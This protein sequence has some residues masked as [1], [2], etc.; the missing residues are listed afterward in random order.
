[1][2]NE[3]KYHIWINF[4]AFL[5]MS[6]L[7][8]G[9]DLI[10]KWNTSLWYISSNLSM[11]RERL[12]PA[13]STNLLTW[14]RSRKMTSWSWTCT[15]ESPASTPARWAGWPWVTRLT[16]SHWPCPQPPAR[17]RPQSWEWEDRLR[18]RERITITPLTTLAPPHTDCVSSDDA[19]PLWWDGEWETGSETLSFSL[20]GLTSPHPTRATP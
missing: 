9:N 8:V 4:S 18:R 15:R 20:P 10:W 14:W 2:F 3:A 7:S 5:E 19:K 13:V 6:H 12:R 17:A 1:M 16:A 11:V